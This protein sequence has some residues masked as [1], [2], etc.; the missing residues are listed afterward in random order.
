MSN[1]RQAVEDLTD[2]ANHIT[3]SIRDNSQKV[4]YLI[5]S[6]VC[7]NSTLQASIGLMR[8]N[9]NGLRN[10]FEKAASA[11][12]EVDPYNWSCRPGAKTTAN[13]SSI[14]FSSGRGTSG[15]DLRWHTR[16]E[17]MALEPEQRDEL[18]SWQKTPEGKTT[19]AKS[20]E[21]HSKRKGDPKTKDGKDDPKK[22]KQWLNKFV[23]SPKGLKHVMFVLA[24][25]EIPNAAFIASLQ[26]AQSAALI[27]P[28]AT[29]L[30]PVPPAAA[31]INS[32]NARF[33]SS[34]TKVTLNSILKKSNN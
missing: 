14:D 24:K 30:T 34:T 32:L 25:E 3:V 20:R 12:I 27:P 17:L 15:V 33:P 29:T 31:S 18:V 7:C 28:A 16:K 11:L 26:A 22:R 10:D 4:E 1:H 23:K 9:I 6:R 8:S 13:V 21:K 2:C 5:D 19:L